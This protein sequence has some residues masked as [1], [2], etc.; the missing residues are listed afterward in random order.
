MSITAT[1]LSPATAGR[2]APHG[3]SQKPQ[4]CIH[5]TEWKAGPSAPSSIRTSNC[6]R[7]QPTPTH[8]SSTRTQIL[9]RAH[10]CPSGASESL[11]RIR[12][13]QG[14]AIGVT[15]LALPMFTLWA[16]R[17]GFLHG[18]VLPLRLLSHS[19]SPHGV[20]GRSHPGSVALVLQCTQCSSGTTMAL[21]FPL[22]ML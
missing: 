19:H 14:M 11:N 17:T 1:A 2:I 20:E 13:L 3:P 22:S 21:M 7:H 8:F 16:S 5:L 6:R 12:Q 18:P 10:A 9:S 15:K 4:A